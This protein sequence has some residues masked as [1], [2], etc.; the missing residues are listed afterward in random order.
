M[1]AAAAWRR[2]RN[3]L[4]LTRAEQLQHPRRSSSSAEVFEQF[5]QNKFLG[6]KRFSLEGA[7]EPDPAARPGSSSAPARTAS[8]RSCI[9]MAHRGRLNVLANI[10]GKSP[11]EIFA[12][13]RGHATRSATSAR[14]DVK[15]HLGY[16][17]RLHRPRR[18]ASVHLSLVLQPEPPRVREPG[19]RRAACAPSRTASATA[20]RTRGLPLLIHGDAAFAGQ[21]VVAGDAQ[22]SRAS[23]ATRIGGTVHVVVNNQIGFTTAPAATRA[24]RTYATDVARMLQIPIFHV[25]GE[26]PEAVAQ[27]VDLAMDFRQ[28]FH[29]DVVIDMYCYRSYGHNEGDEPRFTQPVMYQR[30]RRASRRSARSTSSACVEL[31]RRSP[32]SEADAD[33]GRARRRARGGAARRAQEAT[34][35]PRPSTFAGVVGAHQRRP[36]RRG[37]RRAD[38]GQRR[39][40][41][42]RGRRARSRRCPADFTCTPSSKALVSRRARRWAPARS[43]ST[44]AWARRWRSRT[45]L[46][47]G[48]AR[49]PDRPG[50]AR[51]TF[52]HRHA[53]LHDYDDGRRVHAARSTSRDEQAPLRGLQQPAVRG[54]RAR[55]RVRLQPRHARRAGDLG[56][57]V[58]RLR[59]RRAGDHRSV[60]RRR[61]RTSGTG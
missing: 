18:A 54:G 23:T 52:S 57:A 7:R 28:R 51:G 42:Q 49:A 21:G 31:G 39:A 47:A 25:N 50:R 61:P 40:R 36:G 9:G 29:R 13:V 27:V 24:R 38:R 41:S 2:T 4:A 10:M 58:R 26:D 30:D 33:R 43:R 11:R 34:S 15:Y 6:A 14:G 45:L 56:G 8:T 55:L 19:R 44:G 12:R 5:L 48:R 1:A 59:Q 35:P 17:H 3:R 32:A 37:A 22:L 60:P 46:G 16:S 53:V 20:T